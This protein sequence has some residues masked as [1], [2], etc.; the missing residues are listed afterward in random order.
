MLIMSFHDINIDDVEVKP[1]IMHDV[2]TTRG[3]VRIGARRLFRSLTNT[4]KVS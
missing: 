3:S 1:I 2:H 4:I